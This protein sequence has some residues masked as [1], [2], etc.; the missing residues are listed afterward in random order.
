VLGDE[1]PLS[2][3]YSQPELGIGDNMRDPYRLGS[4]IKTSGKRGRVFFKGITVAKVRRGGRLSK[5]SALKKTRAKE[6]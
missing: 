4:C 3:W 6:T 2:I 1:I 5:R